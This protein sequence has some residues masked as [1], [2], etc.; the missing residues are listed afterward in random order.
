MRVIPLQAG[1]CLNL[2][3]L[4]ERGA[5]W[6]LQ[7]YPAGFSLLLHPV[8]GPVL[9]DTGYG[10]SV[11]RAMRRWPGVLYGLVTPVRLHPQ[12]TA[13][14]QLA[15]MGFAPQDVRHIIV[16]HLHADHVGGLR[17][18]PHATFH[19]DRAAYETLRALRG[20][21]AVRRAFLPEALPADFEARAR[22]LPFQAAPPDLAPF[23]QVADVFGDSSVWAVPLPGHAPGMVGLLVPEA[24]GLSVLAADAAWSVRAARE[25]RPP[26]PLARAAFFDPTQEAASGAQLRAFLQARPHARVHVS[27]DAPEAWR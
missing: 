18:F 3:A 5:P 16:S 20:L 8:H 23:A 2:A 13:R 6:R 14:A 10:E 1:D 27:H 9:F 21:K 24:Q 15:V 4:T 19:L 17:D 11:V 12:A 22:W 7:A 25:A 26:H